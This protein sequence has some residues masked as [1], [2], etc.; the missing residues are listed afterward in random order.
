M[1][2][3]A[4]KRKLLTIILV[5]MLVAGVILLV[6]P[7]AANLWNSTRQT[8]V[9]EQYR[10][11][12]DS[13]DQGEADAIIEAALA[14]NRNLAEQGY[15]SQLG[16]ERETEYQKQLSYNGSDV[17]GYVE[18]NKIDVR[19][20]I[21]HGTAEEELNR[22][23]GHLAGTSLPVGAKSYD[24]ESGR[25]KDPDDGSHCVI[26]GHRGLPSSKLFTDLDRMEVGDTFAL[27][28]FGRT[29]VYEVDQINIVEPADLSLLKLEKGKDYC[30]LL[31]CTPYSINSHRLLVRGVRVSTEDA[32]KYSYRIQQNATMILPA[33]IAVLLAAPVLTLLFAWVMFSPSGRKR[34]KNSIDENVMEELEVAELPLTRLDLSVREI[35][36]MITALTEEKQE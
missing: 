11:E 14:Y 25:V 20:P 18:I 16:I 1:I 34:R 12:L 13:I 5:M 15:G 26:S 29:L 6:Y 10:A 35:N 31:T 24:D 36:R 22:G 2:S 30:T 9:L 32:A 3:A 23:I 17:M 4:A 28:C 19:L 8:R 27:S 33:I 7:F 21:F